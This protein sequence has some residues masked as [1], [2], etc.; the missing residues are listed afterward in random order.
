MLSTTE[1][2]VAKV[3]SS[4]HLIVVVRRVH[5][6]ITIPTQVGISLHLALSDKCCRGQ[7]IFQMG[8]AKYPL[9]SCDCGGG[10]FETFRGDRVAHKFSIQ[11]RLLFKQ[12][13]ADWKRLLLH[14]SEK[15]LELG[16]LFRREVKFVGEF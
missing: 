8:F 10:G 12:L 5:S 11:F 2:A 1:K 4:G 7:V 13:C 9:R 14:G 16:T 3:G 15:F 6:V